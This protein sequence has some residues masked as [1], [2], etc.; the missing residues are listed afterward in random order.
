MSKEGLIVDPMWPEGVK[1]TGEV[2]EEL[3]PAEKFLLENK[4]H[5]EVEVEV[6]GDWQELSRS[7]GLE[8]YERQP[9]ESDEEW[10]AWKTYRDIYPGKLPT[11]SQLSK[12]TGIGVSRLVRMS[13]KW[14]WKVR[15]LHWARSTDAEG[16]DERRKA[17]KAM[18][19]KQLA[20]TDA[21]FDKLREAVDYIDPTVMRPNEITGMLKTVAQLQKDITEYVPEEVV[22]PALDGHAVKQ[23]QVTKKEDIGSIAEIL[24]S[25]GLLDGAT[26]GVRTTELVVKPKEDE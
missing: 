18:Q 13:D 24:S 17:I 10:R 22:Q 8:L 1:P 3:T 25:V 5:A 9:E 19:D 16:A 20:L 6:P 26:L 12:M 15:M 21:M 2:G 11:M 23:S 7:L 4:E 14:S